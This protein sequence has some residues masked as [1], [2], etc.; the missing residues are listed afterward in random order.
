MKDVIP[1]SNELERWVEEVVRHSNHV[2]Y[3]LNNL[4]LGCKDYERPHDLVGF[5]NKLDWR[6]AKGMA[7]SYRGL[8]VDFEKYILPS[9]EFHRNQYHHRMWN[10][11]N[12]DATKE[13]L[14]VGVVDSVCSLLENRSYSGKGYA[15]SGRSHSWEEVEDILYNKNPESKNIA[16]K[17]IIPKMRKLE[18]P[19]LEFID[20]IFN[21]PNI[22][23]RE[24]IYQRMNDRIDESVC[25]LNKYVK[26]F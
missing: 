13:D 24:D 6:A 15:N 22:G 5:G 2:E 25:D 21:F 11:E 16:A 4:D 7:L 3:Y 1:T 8:G 18:R 17:E 9:I 10:H 12:I 14:Y 23:I 26:I 19:R 20:D